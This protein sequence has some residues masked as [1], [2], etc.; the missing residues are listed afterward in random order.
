MGTVDIMSIF[1]PHM[2]VGD[3]DV[4]FR[5]GDRPDISRTISLAVPIE[6]AHTD[7]RVGREKPGD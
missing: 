3:S 2:T 4:G 7:L 5:G 1:G 6:I